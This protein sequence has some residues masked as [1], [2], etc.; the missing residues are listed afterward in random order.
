MEDSM[1]AK[2]VTEG[3]LFLCMSA[4]PHVYF[5]SHNGMDS[6]RRSNEAPKY[7]GFKEPV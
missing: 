2:H 1:L 3:I 5:P 4:C 7:S 6:P